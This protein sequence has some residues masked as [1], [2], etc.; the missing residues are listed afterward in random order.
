MQTDLYRTPARHVASGVRVDYQPDAGWTASPRIT[1]QNRWRGGN[2]GGWSNAEYDRLAQTFNRTLGR[3]ER[4]L[5]RLSPA[6]VLAALD[7]RLP[8]S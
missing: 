8:R 2:R 1:A 7:E 3:P 4:F 6:E 5:G